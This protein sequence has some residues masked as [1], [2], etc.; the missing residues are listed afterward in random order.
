MARDRWIICL[1]NGSVMGE[2][3]TLAEA[4]RQ[5]ESWELVLN[6][7]VEVHAAGD[8]RLME[9][10]DEIMAIERGALEKCPRGVPLVEHVSW[11]DCGTERLCCANHILHHNV[12]V[13]YAFMELSSSEFCGGES[14]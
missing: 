12:Y 8:P 9:R 6:R 10:V 13:G 4:E 14:S 3:L 1:E 5:A 7:P 11:T 2:A